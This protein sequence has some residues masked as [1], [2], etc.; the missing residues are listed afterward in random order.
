[1]LLQFSPTLKNHHLQILIQ[2]GNQVD[3]EPLSRCATSK[4]LFIYNYTYLLKSFNVL[5][6]VLVDDLLDPNF[7]EIVRIPPGTNESFE[8]S[9]NFTEEFVGFSGEAQTTFC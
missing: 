6:I 2:P 9:G 8:Q 4:L 7:Y 1:M 5:K 3:E